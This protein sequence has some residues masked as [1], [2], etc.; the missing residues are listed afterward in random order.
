MEGGFEAFAG[1]LPD[2]FEVEAVF[3]A[4]FEVAVLLAF[5]DALG[6]G[7]D[8]GLLPGKLHGLEGQASDAEVVEVDGVSEEA[9]LVEGG[10]TEGQF[11]KQSSD[12]VEELFVGVIGESAD[13]EFGGLF[14]A[15]AEADLAEFPD[16]A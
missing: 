16:G 10:L 8:G 15:F 11:T 4:G 12:A 3:E 13:D 6:D 2:G 9:G 14:G 7:G 1:H 5:F